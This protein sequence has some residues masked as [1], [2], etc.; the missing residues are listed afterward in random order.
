MLVKMILVL[1]V[2]G[3]AYRMQSAL[4]LNDELLVRFNGNLLAKFGI[5]A[6]FCMIFSLP[7]VIF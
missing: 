2:Y 1:S 6:L 7:I 5:V 4:F 3:Y